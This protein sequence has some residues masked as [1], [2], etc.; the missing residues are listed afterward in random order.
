MLRIIIIL[1]ILVLLLAAFLFPPFR[2]SLWATLVVVLC[3]IAGIIWLDNRERELQHSRLP[4]S[5][6]QLLHMQAKPGL[7]T[8]T[9][10]VNG[11][12]RNQSKEFTINMIKLQVTL[13]DCISERCDVIGQTNHRLFLEVP[14][15]QARNFEASI[16]FPSIVKMR[17]TPEWQFAVLAVKTKK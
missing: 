9:Y 1:L 15:D 2:R 7:N 4:L 17:G 12:I 13:Q 11:R 5:Q 14:P 10:V 8:R 16:P 3:V 6:V